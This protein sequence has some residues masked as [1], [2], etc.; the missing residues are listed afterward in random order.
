MYR[1]DIDLITVDV[2]TREL[3]SSVKRTF[4]KSVVLVGFSHPRKTHCNSPQME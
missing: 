4:G 3:K 1:S 2:I